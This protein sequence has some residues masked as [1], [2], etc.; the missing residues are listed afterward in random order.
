MSAV[1]SGRRRQRAV[2]ASDSEWRALKERAEAAG[3]DASRYIFERLAAPAAAAPP[4]WAAEL[5]GRVERVER[6][7]GV[8]YEVER[9]RLAANGESA[10]WAALERR[11]DERLEVQARLG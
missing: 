2:M 9:Q 5:A 1:Q 3:M 10:T 8:L 7:A 4:P 11:V 6:L